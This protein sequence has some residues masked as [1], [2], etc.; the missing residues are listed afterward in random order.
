MHTLG[1]AKRINQCVSNEKH[2]SQ[3][4]TPCMLNTSARQIPQMRSVQKQRF[5]M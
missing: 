1:K 3:I 5:F 4:G 2:D